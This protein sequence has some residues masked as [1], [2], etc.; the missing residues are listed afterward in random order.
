MRNICLLGGFLLFACSANSY[1]PVPLSDP[2]SDHAAGDS[3]SFVK[4]RSLDQLI[5]TKERYW[6]FIL[7]L[8]EKA[9]N[10][11]EILP[12][13]NARSD[14]ALYRAQV[15]TRSP[16][17]AVIYETGGILIDHG[18][19]RILGGGGTR[20]N[21]GMPE[22]N[23]GKS[24]NEY[25]QAPGFYLVADDVLGGFFAVNGG[26]FGADTKGKVYYFAPDTREWEMMN[27]TFG[28]FLSFCFC[29]DIAKFYGTYRW[30][31]WQEDVKKL[32]PDYGI[33]CFP[34]LF[35]VEGSDIEKV[36]RMPVPIKE[37]WDFQFA[38]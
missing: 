6:P 33:S 15:T 2:L 20:L 9:T 34:F 24:F 10:V 31:G 8:K 30:K 16:M 23:K 38:Q 17:G 1:Q 5:N 36:S 11:V 25:G 26:A 28:E 18:W 19:I 27:V 22:W 3:S 4:L 7:E 29:G 21:R 32:D 37:L 12:K 13:D 14:S 35:T